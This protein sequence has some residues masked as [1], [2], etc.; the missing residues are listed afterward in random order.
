MQKFPDKVKKLSARERGETVGKKQF[1]SNNKTLGIKCKCPFLPVFRVIPNKNEDKNW[2][3]RVKKKLK[4][5]V[6]RMFKDKD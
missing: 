1:E 5:K 4:L 3:F 2:I 6:L